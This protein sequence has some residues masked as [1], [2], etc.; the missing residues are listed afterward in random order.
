[1][2]TFNCQGCGVELV[3]PD[4]KQGKKGKCPKCKT[5]IIVPEPFDKTSLHDK[6]T[7]VSIKDKRLKD[8]LDYLFN[9]SSFVTVDK[10]IADEEHVNFR[11][12][13]SEGTTV[14]SQAVGVTLFHSEGTSE[15]EDYIVI[16]SQI[17][18]IV[19]TSQALTLLRACQTM[20]GYGAMLTEDMVAWVKC[21]LALSNCSKEEFAKMIFQV[22]LSADTLENVFFDWDLV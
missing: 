11:I 7:K 9:E 17:G 6:T 8:L 14:R 1:M 2:I 3:V 21:D 22:A 13:L 15:R 19:E 16:M 5:I 12:V 18:K 20:L 10:S 4:E